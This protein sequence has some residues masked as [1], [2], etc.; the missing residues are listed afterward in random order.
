MNAA[1]RTPSGRRNTTEE[2]WA[3]HRTAMSLS[4][5]SYSAPH[6][7]NQVAAGDDAH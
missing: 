3:F 5:S 7:D 4:L 2:S 1:S 6:S